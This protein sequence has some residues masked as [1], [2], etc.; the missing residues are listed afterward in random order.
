MGVRIARLHVVGLAVVVR[1][2][3]R[4]E[5]PFLSSPVHPF[6]RTHAHRHAISQDLVSW[7]R[8]N[9]TGIRGS[10]GG[11]VALPAGTVGAGSQD[12]WRAAVF[13]SA[14]K[15]PQPDPVGLSVWYSEHSEDEDDLLAW[16]PYTGKSAACNGSFAAAVVCPGMVPDSVGAGYVGDNY[17]WRAEN[18][19][20]YLLSGSNKCIE[21]N[22]TNIH[23]YK[24][25]PSLTQIARA[26]LRNQERPA[27]VGC[28][29][30]AYLVCCNAVATC[31]AVSTCSAAT[32][33][34]ILSL[35]VHAL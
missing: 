12:R 16:Q 28:V 19:T 35:R 1:N 9:R 7:R 11:G 6:K 29:A 15:Y 34:S 18:G 24:T 2:I 20:Y 22:G 33:H 25:K 32:A 27:G 8:L 10:S 14:P 31:P 17:V 23:T 30:V 3:E 21:N 4:E 5:S 13:T 26:A